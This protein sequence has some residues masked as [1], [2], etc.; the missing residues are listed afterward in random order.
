MNLGARNGPIGRIGIMVVTFRVNLNESNIF[1][2]I[3]IHHS[4]FFTIILLLLWSTW[5]YHDG[6]GTYRQ[7]ASG[8]MWR[9]FKN[10]VKNFFLPV[11][12]IP[13]CGLPFSTLVR[14]LYV[15]TV[16]RPSNE[17]RS[18]IFGTAGG[19]VQSAAYRESLAVR[20]CGHFL[21]LLLPK[22]EFRWILSSI[23]NPLMPKKY[24]LYLYII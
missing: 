22:T 2:T 21:F 16:S 13:G 17:S 15:R 9:P 18:D 10:L 8:K 3:S 11:K 19:P 6:K 12:R 4:F 20:L 24:F 14:E 5:P 23:I 7:R 1:F